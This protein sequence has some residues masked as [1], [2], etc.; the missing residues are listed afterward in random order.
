MNCHLL[1]PNLFWPVAAGAEPYRDLEL[2]SLQALLARGRRIRT[3]GGSLERWLASTY[4]LPDELPLAPFALR[5]NGGEPGDHCWMHAD[6]VHLRVHGDRLILADASRFSIAK[7]EASD[8]VEALNSH[9]AA[10]GVLF[11]APSPQRWYLRLAAEPRMRAIPT[12]EMAGRNIQPFLPSGEDGARWRRFLNETQMVLHGHARNEAR[13]ALPVNSVW[14]W[15]AGRGCPLASSYDVVWSDHP[16][17]AGLAAASG[18]AMRPLPASGASLL[19]ESGFKTP[20]VVVASLPATT[21]GDLAGWRDGIMALEQTWFAPLLAGLKSAALETLTLHG[22]GPDHGYT[23]TVSRRDLWRL[24][25]RKRPL[26]AYA[27]E[28][29]TEPPMNADENQRRQG[30][31]RIFQIYRATEKAEAYYCLNPVKEALLK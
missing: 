3:G 2:P 29:P 7:E 26:Q 15:G 10:E 25:R 21:Y 14:L 22:L 4:G 5:G 6:P 18:A 9:F 31:K 8:F 20:L 13:G 19:R 11:V 27:V 23:V 17:A 24:W 16:L 1:V 12:A 28:K 30:I